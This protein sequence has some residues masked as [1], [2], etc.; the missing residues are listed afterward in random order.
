MKT[1]ILSPMTLVPGTILGAYEIQSQV[2]AGGMGEV[3]RARDTRLDRTV[4]IKILPTHLAE[5]SDARER[6]ERE[7]RAISA[8]NHP[9]ICHLYDVGSHDG[10]RYLVMEYLEGETLA[11]RLIRGPLPPEQVLKYG[12]EIC[13]ALEQAHRTGVVHRDLK[14]GN[15]MLTKSG[16]K[17][18]DFGL[19]RAAS[20]EV[21]S[22][23]LGPT[24][25][26]PAGM[27]PLTAEGTVVGTFQYMS[28]EQ[29]EGKEADARSDIF[30]LGATLYEMATG[31]RAFEG[32]TTASVFAAVLERHPRPI[33]ALQPACP[34]A[35]ERIVQ[36]CLAKDPDD[37][38]RSAYDVR[39]QLAG[40][41]EDLQ[42]PSS[43]VPGGHAQTSSK[44]A[45]GLVI[46]FIGAAAW[47]GA[48][49]HFRNP[50]VAQTVRSSLL[51]PPHWSFLVNNAAVSPDGTRLAFVGVGQNGENSIWVRSLSTG[52]EQ[53]LSGTD[54][55]SVPFWSPDSTRLGFFADS[56]LKIVDANGG[57]Q[58]RTLSETTFGRGGT[59]NRDGTIVYAPDMFGVLYRIS[60][61]GG[62][63]VAI[64]KA[65]QGGGGQ[66]HR[67]PSFLPDGRHFL[68]SID[69]CAPDEK[70]GNGIY[71]GSLDGG[72]SKLVTS[73]FTGN[74][75]FASGRL[76]YVRDLTLTAQPF[77]PDKLRITGP[78]VP[79][80]VPQVV[81][82]ESFSNSAFSVSETGVL[83]YQAVADLASQLLWFNAKGE[84]VGQIAS[85]APSEPRLSPD[86]RFVAFRSDEAGNGKRYLRLYD[87]TRDVATRLTDQGAEES[88]A[89]SPDGKT[90]VYI[91][92][93]GQ[94][95][96]I[97]QIALD[98]ADPPR[99]LWKGP[100]I[101]QIDHTLPDVL[102][103]SEFSAGRP[104]LMT[105]SLPDV[106]AG[107]MHPG[108]EP[109]ISPDGHWVVYTFSSGHPFHPDVY[110]EPFRGQGA[111]I[112]IS[113][114]GGA[115]GTWSR[116][117]KQIY[118]I[119]PDKK[120]MAV[121]FDASHQSVG[122]PQ[123][124]FQT[125]IVSPNFDTRQYDV[126]PDGRLLIN[127]L[128]PGSAPP[129]TLLTNWSGEK[130]R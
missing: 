103:C 107:L 27:A 61:N 101:R 33:C 50:A 119:A 125:R 26:S 57:G 66:A 34:P 40:L 44:I 1:I 95:Y 29:V 88:P 118:F 5:K 12:V 83:V 89:W 79:V 94:S 36:T 45:W 30:A 70:P 69:W 106:Q 130:D 6:F 19:A 96:G 60:E 14:P 78:A 82:S 53:Q 59:W 72:D 38:W 47:F 126:A 115:Q 91:S 124:L 99:T 35:L 42:A 112:Q 11:N 74:A 9:H 105:L 120:M 64:T 2:G 127:S 62:S 110:L 16:A 87:T 81:T 104:R 39:L 114:N 129:I 28:P 93:D 98:R 41:R 13:D 85:V 10:L 58:P 84:Q 75:A 117:G 24:M 122:A 15:I 21:A 86:G 100:R 23:G 113:S 22:S 55:A 97:Y 90:L 102:L 73:E 128:L 8:L 4:A 51:P 25:S 80:G 17:L 111:R 77:D 67:W 71:V 52:A 116:D 20:P 48:T 76:V 92:R 54:G 37:R 65:P 108:A 68:Y 7:A 49:M 121:S 56:K 18:L 43:A 123:V 31:Q 46:L 63:P 32:K 3:Y 109:R